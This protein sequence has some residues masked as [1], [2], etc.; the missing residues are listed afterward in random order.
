MTD[1]HGWAAITVEFLG[2]TDSKTV[3]HV[4]EAM[5]G[6]N[7]RVKVKDQQ[8]QDMRVVSVLAQQGDEGGFLLSS[9]GGDGE[10]TSDEEK[11]IGYEDIEAIGVY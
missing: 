2:S 11:L 5:R 3:G 4:F 1:Q 10:P 8:H 7:V 6:W 9:I